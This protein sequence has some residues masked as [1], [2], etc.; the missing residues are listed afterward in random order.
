ML[1]C[2]AQFQW[3]HLQHT[4][5]PKAQG[6]LLN[7]GRKDS[8]GHKIRWDQLKCQIEPENSTRGLNQDYRQYIKPGRRSCD[9]P[10]QEHMNWFLSAK[11]LAIRTSIQVSLYR[12]KGLYLRIY[13]YIHVYKQLKLM[14]K[15]ILNLKEYRERYIK[16]FGGRRERWKY[17][18]III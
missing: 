16:E 4:A 7:R 12:L 15:G 14:K 2:R 11:W 13:V 8:K 18:Y 1:N 10:R 6:T 17:N 3:L 9:I 5:A